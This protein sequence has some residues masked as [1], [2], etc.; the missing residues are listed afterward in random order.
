MNKIII[1]GY[2]K[3]KEHLGKI[4]GIIFKNWEDSEPIDKISIIINNF[5]SYIPGEFY[6]RELPGIVKLLEN[7]DLDKFDTIILDSHVWLWNYEES[8][9]KP[10]PG[11]GAHLY[12]KLGRKNLNIIGIAKSY[13]CDNNMHTFSCFR[14][15]SKNPL[16][17]D[18]INQ[19]KDYSEVIKSMYGNFRIP[20]LIKLADTESKINFK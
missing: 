8:F 14:G 13:Y 2:Y 12:E 3:E 5:D 7:I 19:D 17:V 4:S 10:K 20:Y 15:N 11:L 1:D 18:S 16:Y 6:K 9:E